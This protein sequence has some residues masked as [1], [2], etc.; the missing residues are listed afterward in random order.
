M[1]Y[2]VLF[3]AEAENDL[4]GIADYIAQDNPGGARTFADELMVFL[5]DK[6][7]TF[8]AS[9]PE[10][11]RR[12][13]VVFGNDVILYRIEDAASTVLVQVIVEGHRS[14]REAFGPSA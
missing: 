4:A 3:S 13:Y 2:S 1:S 8:P 10:V 7:S 11:G 9:G 12:R 6:L 5:T 14:W